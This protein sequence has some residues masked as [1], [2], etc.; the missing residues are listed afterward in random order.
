MHPTSP[1]PRNQ[2]R[3]RSSDRYGHMTALTPHEWRAGL[4]RLTVTFVVLMFVIAAL[5]A[6]LVAFGDATWASAFSVATALPAIVLLLGGAGTHIRSN[7]KTRLNS[8]HLSPEE[9]RAQRRSNDALSAGLLALGAVL[10][11]VSVSLR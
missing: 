8:R 7:G 1:F 11:V 6:G 4:R 2:L 9:L 3:V 10:F 5:A